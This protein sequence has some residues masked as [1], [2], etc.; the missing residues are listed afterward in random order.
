MCGQDRTVIQRVISLCHE[1]VILSVF[2]K[3]SRIRHC[4]AR[5]SSGGTTVLCFHCGACTCLTVVS[6]VCITCAK[7]RHTITF[8]FTAR[9]MFC[10]DTAAQDLKAV[11]R[12]TCHLSSCQWR[13]FHCCLLLASGE[14]C[15]W[16]LPLD[17]TGPYYLSVLIKR[18]SV[19]TFSFWLPSCSGRSHTVV[20]SHVKTP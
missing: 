7:Q 12:V 9:V 6:V 18:S 3:D 13:R 17:S 8:V 16:A 11:F 5:T 14:N 2:V 1:T 4:D 10:A 20:V 19:E 15:S